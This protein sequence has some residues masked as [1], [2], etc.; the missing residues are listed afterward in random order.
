MAV[1]AVQARRIGAYIIRNLLGRQLRFPLVLMLE[2]L[3]QCNFRCKG[4]GKV[5][6]PP[7]V[8][9][10]M[11]T[12]QQCLDAAEECGAPVVSIPGGEP[13]LHPDIPEVVRGLVA[14]GRFVY[15]CTNAQL[16]EQRI[17]EFNPSPF[18]TFNVHLDGL[19]EQHD[20]SVSHPGAFDKAVAAIRLLRT[21]GFRVTTNSTFFDGHSP[22]DAARLFD[23]LST[24]DVEGLTI[25]PGF[26]YE[27]APVQD[28]FLGRERTRQLFRE[29]F[30]L[31]KGR[32]WR[33]NHSSLYLDFLA[34]NR[35]YGC[36]P[37]GNPTYNIFGWQ[38]PCYLLD[39]G[40]A[41]SFREL[42]EETEW[43]RYGSGRD[44]RCADCMVHCGYEPSAV[45]DTVR[46]PL[47]GLA[48]ALRGPG[49]R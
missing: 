47:R 26:S 13:L 38:R 39:D 14:Q 31:G 1:P 2:P 28:R 45:L 29:I 10:R 3:F 19:R 4:C 30:R 6:H 20:E 12:V 17:H 48:V 16:V 35:E 43:E 42:M 49:G 18:L 33:F 8:L 32:G 41:E 15:L 5:A 46:H 25:S 44:P 9:N 24:L 23:F 21:R 27:A 11:L 37:W 7:E 40:Y 36:T 22:H 34:G